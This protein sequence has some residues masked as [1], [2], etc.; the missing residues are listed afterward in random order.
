M[1][2]ELATTEDIVKELLQRQI[3]FAFVAIEDTNTH[4][5]ETACFSGKGVDER[6]VSDLFEIGREVFEGSGDEFGNDDP[7]FE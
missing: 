1:E 2:L 5:T 4:R 6:D 3:R 7:A